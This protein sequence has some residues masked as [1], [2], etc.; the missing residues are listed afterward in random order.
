[1]KSLSYIVNRSAAYLIYCL[2]LTLVLSF[3]CI[4]LSKSEGFLFVNHCHNKFL[5]NFFILFTNL[6]NGLFAIGL[7]VIMVFRKKI[8]WSIQTGISFLISGLIAQVLKHLVHSPRPR[9]FFGAHEIHWIYGITR[10]GYASF[11]SGHTA[12]IF[13]LCTLLSFYF[14]GRKS[15]LLFFLIAALTGFSRIYLSDHFPV[16]VL[17]GLLT[18]VLSSLVVYVAFPNKKIER[19]LVKN[20]LKSQS[21]NLQ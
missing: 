14:P 6:G 21:A 10:T 7:M 1:M 15:G 8:G 16:D 11:P 4:F 18:G 9:L 20:D 19:K 2:I 5:D 17:G 12:T 13:A 3:Y